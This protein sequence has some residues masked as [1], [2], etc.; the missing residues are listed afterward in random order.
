MPHLDTLHM[1]FSSVLQAEA[2]TMLN[3]FSASFPL[4]L[5]VCL[6]SFLPG[7][8]VQPLNLKQNKKP[9]QKNHPLQHKIKFI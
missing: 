4:I 6:P 5:P 1:A 3:V 2:R 8:I 7:L 9:T